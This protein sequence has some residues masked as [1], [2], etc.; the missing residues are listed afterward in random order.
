MLLEVNQPLLTST[1]FVE[2]V[3]VNKRKIISDFRERRF[4]G[5]HLKLQGTSN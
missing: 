2:N 5:L 1:L 4:A 3:E